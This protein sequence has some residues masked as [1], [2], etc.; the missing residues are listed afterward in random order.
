[1]LFSPILWLSINSCFLDRV[2]W[3]KL[4]QI[5]WHWLSL[6]ESDW[7]QQKM[8]RNGLKGD[9]KLGETHSEIAETSKIASEI[10]H[11]RCGEKKHLKRSRPAER[12]ATSRQN[13]S[14]PKVSRLDFRYSP[15]NLAQGKQRQSE[16]LKMA[17]S[18]EKIQVRS[19][20]RDQ[21]SRSFSFVRSGEVG[22]YK[23]QAY[24]KVWGWQA[25]TRPEVF[26]PQ[27]IGSARNTVGK[28]T[29]PTW[30]KLVKGAFLS[31]QKTAKRRPT[32]PS[33][34]KLAF[35]G[36]TWSKLVPYTLSH[37]TPR[38]PEKNPFKARGSELPFFE[39][40]LP[41]CSPNFPGHIRTIPSKS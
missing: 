22:A 37:R 5:D 1:M 13:R 23:V 40:S 24:T 16:E 19:R 30:S 4:I 20:I 11:G 25:G 9:E 6:T 38:T 18:E 26:P 8:D 33:W 3:L 12:G 27:K 39:E 32:W 31:R 28:S 14:C 35:L 7:Q 34:S 2:N 36:P 41:S 15:A 17:V 29:G 21:F 10:S